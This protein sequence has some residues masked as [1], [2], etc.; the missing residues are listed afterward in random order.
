MI[1]NNIHPIMSKL[2][3]VVPL[4]KTVA[5]YAF[6]N[7]WIITNAMYRDRKTGKDIK[8]VDMVGYFHFNCGNWVRRDELI[9]LFVSH[10]SPIYT[11]NVRVKP[12]LSG[13]DDHDTNEQFINDLLNIFV[14][15]RVG[16]DDHQMSRFTVAE[17]WFDEVMIAFIRYLGHEIPK[18]LDGSRNRD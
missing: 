4:S 14:T 13:S 7:N 18:M 11:I 5:D 2:Q 6:H 17:R 12:E 15:M 16:V 9:S 1:G 3:F 10:D 8:G